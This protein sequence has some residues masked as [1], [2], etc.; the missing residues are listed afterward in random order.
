M[1]ILLQVIVAIAV[2]TVVWNSISRMLL[3]LGIREEAKKLDEKSKEESKDE[4]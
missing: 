2:I 1:L 3:F 4:N